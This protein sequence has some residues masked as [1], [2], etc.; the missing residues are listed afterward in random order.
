MLFPDSCGVDYIG[1][2][3]ARQMSKYQVV[4]LTPLAAPPCASPVREHDPR[5]DEGPLSAAP[6]EQIGE[7]Q[8]YHGQCILGSDNRSDLVLGAGGRRCR[9]CVRTSDD[10]KDLDDERRWRH[11]PPFVVRWRWSDRVT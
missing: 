1:D 9:W 2:G 8:S 3:R 11:R 7:Y 4:F 5:G 6:R 10:D